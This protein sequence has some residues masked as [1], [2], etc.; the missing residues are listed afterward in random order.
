MEETDNSLASIA[1][2]L[3][4]ELTTMYA[5]G[6]FGGYDT[7]DSRIRKE[8]YGAMRS[9]FTHINVFN[10][11]IDSNMIV[12]VVFFEDSNVSIVGYDVP[13]TAG[14]FIATRN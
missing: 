4:N 7:E 3:D 10:D 5:V 11:V 14:S 1:P 2:F 6:T 12:A 13:V 9:K 8:L